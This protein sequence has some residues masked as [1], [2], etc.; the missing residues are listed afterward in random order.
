M[1]TIISPDQ[2]QYHFVF[3]LSAKKMTIIRNNGSFTME[4]ADIDPK[5]LY[6]TARPGRSRAFLRADQFIGTWMRHNEIFIEQ[7]PEVAVIYSTMQVDAANATAQAIPL[8]ISNPKT[9]GKGKNSWVFD[10]ACAST[11]LLAGEYRDI[12]LFIDWLP[13][14][15][16]PKPIKLELPGLFLDKK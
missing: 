5:I 14:V 15:E 12:V 2:K 16:C 1:N 8:K 10:L 7:P 6:M 3:M 11:H 9:A 4:V 13:N